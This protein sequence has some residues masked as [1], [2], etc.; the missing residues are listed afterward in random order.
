VGAGTARGDLSG[1][2]DALE[3]VHRQF[4]H[5]VTDP[6]VLARLDAGRGAEAR[7]L[8]ATRGEIDRDYYWLALTT[9][10]AHA[11]ARLGDA[12][13]AG[14]LYEELRPYAGRLAGADSGTLYV[15]PVDAALAALAEVL[16][17][18]PAPH[19]AAAAQLLARVRDELTRTPGAPGGGTAPAGA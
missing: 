15:G 8:W 18:D 17:L 2:R 12:D 10:R 3:T 1:V 19:R 6:L 9:L 4:P 16:G 5:R 14:P 7:A 13:A 11:A